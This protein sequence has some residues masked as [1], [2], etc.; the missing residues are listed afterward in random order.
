MGRFTGAEMDGGGEEAA[1]T[2]DGTGDTENLLGSA[3]L[4]SGIAGGGEGFSGSG[5]ALTS[6]VF[7]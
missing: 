7:F 3:V 4:R 6:F 1:F 5:S 2:T